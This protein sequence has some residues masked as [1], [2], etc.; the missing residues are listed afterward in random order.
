[1]SMSRRKFLGSSA[2][3][4]IV[5]GTM[6]KGKVFGANE[7]V[8]VACIGF[9][10]RGKDHVKNFGTVIPESEVV[11]LCDVDKTVLD[12]MAALMKEK[13]GKEPAKF[14][15]GREMVLRDDI[16]AISIA[17]PN[18]SHTFFAVLGCLNKKDV[19]VEKPICHTVWEGQQ[20]AAAAKK[21]ERIVQH[22]TQ[23]RSDTK[24][25]AAMQMMRDGAIGEIHTARGL[26]YK[27]GN[28]GSLGFKENG[29]P[30]PNL[31][32]NLWQGPT[33]EGPYNPNYHPYNWHWFWKYGNGEIGNQGVHQMD[34]AVWGMNKG[35]PVKV[36][37]GG[38]RYTYKDMGETPNTNTAIFTYADG[39]ELIFDVRNRFTNR[40]GGKIVGG[41]VEEGGKITGDAKFMEAPGTG[42]IFYGD[43]GYYIE[44][45]GFYDV[46]DNRME[47]QVD[48]Q[49]GPTHMANFIKAVKSRKPED[50]MASAEV[51]HRS[52]VHIHIA[53]I[54]Y[55]LGRS[56]K[57]DPET[58]KFVGDDEAN[59]MLTKEYRKGF[60]VP[61][62]A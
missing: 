6:A 27:N 60:E 42:N 10:G 45:V 23:S 28:R 36:Y 49:P 43:K 35:L 37:S 30:P 59:A 26:G 21:Y 53:N 4:V 61:Q 46:D 62:I 12:G 9:N 5:A 34:I 54:S 1:M 44:D 2:A 29:T 17:T 51:A 3:A 41:K 11:A 16:D 40:E 32:W 58:L 38:G 22:G 8:R 15:D 52:C 56:L 24:W 25:L 50:N 14:A 47:K 48:V 7:K 20:I 39:T 13:T 57:F 18:F 19:Y 31:D 55:R 33:L